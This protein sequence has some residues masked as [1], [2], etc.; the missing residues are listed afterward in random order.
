MGH[1]STRS[2]SRRQ[3]SR[4]FDFQGTAPHQ[5]H[6]FQATD[7]CFGLTF[8]ATTICFAGRASSGQLVMVL[9]AGL[10]TGCW[11]L[12]QLMSRE[13]RYTWTGTEWLW[14]LGIAIGV[15]QVVPL[16]REWMLAISPQMNQILLPTGSKG[17]LD[18]GL[19]S[20]NQLSLAPWESVSGLATFIAYAMLFIVLVQRL[21]KQSDVER[22]ML[23]VGVI[24]IAMAVFAQVQCLASNGKFYWVYEH[25]F[26][27]TDN[28][29]HGSFTN[30]NHLS[31]FLALGVGPLIWGILRERR[32]SGLHR[33][34]SD[35]G[36]RRQ[37]TWI[38]V[39]MMLGL[40]CSLVTV[41]LTSSRGGLL[42][43]AVAIAVCF[44]GLLWLRVIPAE[45]CV[46]LVVVACVVGGIVNL[47]GRETA[48]ED[49]LKQASGREQVWQAN[50]AV[51]KDFPYLGTGVGTHNDAHRLHLE[52]PTDGVEFTH[53]E[54]SYLQ[55]LSETGL[56]GLGLAGL[57]I[58]VSLRWCLGAFFSADKQISSLA[59]A[60]LA[61]LMANVAHAVGDFFWYTPSCMML[62]AMQL[63]CACRLYQLTRESSGHSPW[64]WQVPRL[65]CVP[66]V[67][68]V[69]ALLVW[70]T[71]IKLPAAMAEP[72]QMRYIA[73][74]LSE[75]GLGN[76]EVDHQESRH[77]MWLAASKAAK[78]NP[79]NSRLLETAALNCLE[80]FNERQ[81]Q[82]E[83]SIP[84]SQLRDAIR[85]SEFE[86][87]AAMREWLDRA[88]G[89]NVKLLQIARKY[90]RQS[91]R[92][93]PLRA[94]SY[95]QLAELGFLDGLDAETETAYLKQA[96]VLRG[97]DP[98]VLFAIGRH[99]SLEGDTDA[100]MPYWC[101]A[102]ELSPMTRH[103]ITELLVPQVSAEFFLANLKPEWSSLR[104][105][106]QAFDAVGRQEE[107]L[108]IWQK[109]IDESSTS[110]KAAKT[111]TEREQ[112]LIAVYDGFMA[113]NE[114]DKA[115][116]LLT[117]AHQQ[118]P[119]SIPIRTQLAW[120]LY[121][122][123]RYAEA[124]E[125]LV[126]LSSRNPA[127]KSLQNAAS[128][129]TKERMRTAGVTDPNS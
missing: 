2:S 42:A 28:T 22:M 36:P 126:W 105:V 17:S 62:L 114:S 101:E 66:A 54:S 94:Q 32:N 106:A 57:F 49:R 65:L 78:L 55:V 6:S 48:M 46:G 68:G 29:P 13:P 39:S 121:R 104:T 33:S 77:E 16:P 59:V 80:L 128:K 88:V 117:K 76:D 107:G 7:V 18:L 56:V 26:M 1:Q 97:H 21:K 15:A 100:A 96:L 60:I 111:R 129:A 71:L 73:L 72:E 5:S 50:I 67:G 115:I 63:A 123:E 85:A 41:L 11:A 75:P 91:L 103:R 87:P 12:R 14:L 24:V 74:S 124:A 37:S 31:Q 82:T 102:F 8:L 51:A 43:V 83:N 45:F 109:L 9:G 92:E 79:H 25:P 116:K 108:Q 118:N 40:G 113:L 64:T 4:S 98:A 81:E 53:A 20:W 38:T 52:K 61:S 10:T 127:D 35:Q 44:A 34:H 70:M 69:L 125:H 30:H 93:S 122:T 90:F 47:T 23:A 95:I 3:G 27:T 19:E 89:K 99:A 86:S 58:L 112:A 110:L 119:D 120:G 84:L